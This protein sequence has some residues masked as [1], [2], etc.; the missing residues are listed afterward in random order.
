[1]KILSVERVLNSSDEAGADESRVAGVAYCV[2][3]VLICME[4]FKAQ[5]Q[6]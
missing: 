2:M 6:T 5:A 4:A 1:M 3:H